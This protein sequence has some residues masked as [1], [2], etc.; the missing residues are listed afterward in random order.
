M[1]RIEVISS[2]DSP[3]AVSEAYRHGL[4]NSQ[5]VCLSSPWLEKS[6]LSIMRETIPSGA[7]LDLLIK[8]PEEYDRTYRAIEALDIVSNEMRWDVSVV[9][10]PS[11]HAK[12]TIVDDKN[13]LFGSVNAT[14]GGLYDNIEILTAFYEQPNIADCFIKVFETIKRYSQ[15]QSWELVRGFHGKSI[16]RV[17]IEIARRYFREE[18]NSEV[19]VDIFV[20]YLQRHGFSF[21]RAKEGLQEMLKHG[22]LYSPRDGYIKLVPKYW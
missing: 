20:S 2:L 6:F 22:V 15:N 9:C 8:R 12:F 16:D 4:R 19:R 11:L 10:V 17:T 3:F 18:P 21:I 13:V 1:P 7:S 5:R 14:N